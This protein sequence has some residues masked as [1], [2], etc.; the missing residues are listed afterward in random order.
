[1]KQYILE[2]GIAKECPDQL[3]WARWMEGN[4][5][6]RRVGL[7]CV[8]SVKVSTVFLGVDHNWVVGGD[9]ELF[10]T[11]TFGNEDWEGDQV[12]YSTLEQA[13]NGHAEMVAIVR[14]RKKE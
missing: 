1:M 8:G 4:G 2:N 5:D 7:D 14:S 11:M 3:Q 9:P 12:R 6:A 10:E 13:K